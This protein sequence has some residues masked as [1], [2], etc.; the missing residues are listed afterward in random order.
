M[1]EIDHFIYT[2]VLLLSIAF[3]VAATFGDRTDLSMSISKKNQVE[4]QKNR[5][6]LDGFYQEIFIKEEPEECKKFC[7]EKYK[8][9]KDLAW[10]EQPWY[11]QAPYGERDSLYYRYPLLFDN[12]Y[13]RIITIDPLKED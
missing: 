6:I 8:F 5:D 4:I 12:M 3:I 1:K 10:T 13:K 2:W 9:L 7:R 11:Y